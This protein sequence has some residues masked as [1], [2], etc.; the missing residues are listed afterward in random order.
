MHCG[1]R[2]TRDGLFQ[3]CQS[4]TC[5]PSADTRHP[6]LDQCGTLWRLRDVW[7]RIVELV[8]P[9]PGPSINTNTAKKLLTFLF[10]KLTENLT[11]ALETFSMNFFICAERGLC[12][13]NIFFFFN[14]KHRSFSTEQTL[15]MGSQGVFA[16]GRDS[17]MFDYKY[18]SDSRTVGRLQVE[19]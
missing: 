16:G 11:T 3:F 12:F 18:V 15:V 19:E 4:I 17:W 13:L 9:P 2:T 10:F 1:A 6:W 8:K 7:S 14:P 5:L